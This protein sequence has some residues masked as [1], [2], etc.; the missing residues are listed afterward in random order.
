[1]SFSVVVSELGRLSLEASHGEAGDTGGK[2]EGAFSSAQEKALKVA[3][4]R[5]REAGLLC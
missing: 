2:D 5:G 1:M 4:A 3:F